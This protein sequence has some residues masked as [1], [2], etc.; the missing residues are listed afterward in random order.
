MRA[1]PRP[2]AAAAATARPRRRLAAQERR[3]LAAPPAPPHRLA[4]RPSCAR[5][6]RPRRRSGARAARRASAT[7]TSS[8]RRPSRAGAA[9]CT[10]S[11]APNASR[12]RDRVRQAGRQHRRQDLRQRDRLRRP[13]PTSTSTTSPSP[14]ARTRPRV[15][16]PA[17]GAVLHRRRQD[18][19]PVQPEPARA[20]SRRQQQRPRRQ[21]HHH[22]RARSA[23]RLPHQRAPIRSS[24]PSRPPACARD[25]CINGAPATRPGQ[26]HA[27]NGGAWAQVSRLGMPLVNEVVIGLDDKDRFNASK[28]QDDAAN[29]ADYVTNPMLPAL[30]QTL[31]PAAVAPTNFPRTDLLTAFLTGLE[32][33][34]SRRTWWPAEMMRLNTSIAPVAARRAEPARRRRRRHGR[35]PERPP[36]GRRRRRR[37][38]ARRD[39]RAVRAHR[40]DRCA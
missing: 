10:E 7:A 2:D 29:F 1:A 13:M 36:P 32:A 3:A 9:T 8:A 21:E 25:A 39:G 14:A 26:G 12:R 37:V 5:G 20:G 24:A 6:A 40:R 16:R 31:F 35:L 33:S 30:I 34:T 15:R 18:L 11:A 17:Q 19:R 28:P 23:D 38:A 22:A 27:S 4:G